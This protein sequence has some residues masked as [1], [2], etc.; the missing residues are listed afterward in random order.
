MKSLNEKIEESIND[1]N[2]INEG[3]IDAMKSILGK[4]NKKSDPKQY[5]S[6]VTQR[7]SEIADSIKEFDKVNGD[8]ARKFL[9]SFQTTVKKISDILWKSESES[10]KQ[11]ILDLWSDLDKLYDIFNLYSKKINEIST[12]K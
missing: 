2:Y 5:I 8:N 12:L 3:F 4:S 7:T 10:E 9:D 6:D 1:S 11:L